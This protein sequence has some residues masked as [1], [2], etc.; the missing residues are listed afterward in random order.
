MS[1]Q[2]EEARPKAVLKKQHN[3]K[4][5]ANLELEKVHNNVHP[6]DR[7]S[8]FLGNFHNHVPDYTES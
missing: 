2:F 7:G 8:R 3:L 5:T 6:E 4:T 1:L